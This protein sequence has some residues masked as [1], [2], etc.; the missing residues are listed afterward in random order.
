LVIATFGVAL[1]VVTFVVRI[2]LPVG[3][4]FAPL[5]FQLAHFPQYQ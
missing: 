5:N 3:W 2:W 4:F 1:G